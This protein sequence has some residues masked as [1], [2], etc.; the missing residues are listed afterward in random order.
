MIVVDALEP[1]VAVGVGL[2]GE[3]LAVRGLQC[4]G[5]ADDDFL[6]HRLVQGAGDELLRQARVVDPRFGAALE[7]AGDGLALGDEVF[8]LILV[9]ELDGLGGA[10]VRA[11]GFVPAVVDQM[12]ATGALLRQVEVFVEEDHIV[13]A[14]GHAEAAAGALLGIEDDQ[15]VIAL[16]GRARDGA[17]FDARSIVTVLAQVRAVSHLHLRHG[18][19]DLLLKVQPELADLRLRFGDGRPVVTDVLVL[20]D[21]LAVVAAIAPS[22][23]DDEYLLAH[24]Y[25]P[26][27]IQLS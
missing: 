15:A 20:A 16:V 6:F 1:E 12:R 11:A 23:V 7:L 9:H 25:L 22:G 10:G 27:L 4:R 3:D 2:G 14:G 19:A 26:S 18:A 21:D 17:R 8:G 5:R 24:S 13:R